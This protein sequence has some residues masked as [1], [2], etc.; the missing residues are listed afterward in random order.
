MRVQSLQVEGKLSILVK[1][2][3][4]VPT[5]FRIT[6]AVGSKDDWT[7]E[8]F[9]FVDSNDAHGFFVALQP[10]F[11]LF[12]TRGVRVLNLFGKSFESA[13]YSEPVLN[14]HGMQEL[15]EMKYVGKT[16][17]PGWVTEQPRANTLLQQQGPQHLDKTSL[18]PKLMILLKLHEPR[19]PCMVIEHQ[20]V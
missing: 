6:P 16:A 1:D 4:L 7:F 14:A 2:D 15:G 13:R 8:T 12:R 9:A 17:L 5:G 10:L 11:I 18:A 3:T 20:R 19:V